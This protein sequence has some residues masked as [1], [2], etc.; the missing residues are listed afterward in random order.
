MYGFDLRADP[1]CIQGQWFERRPPTTLVINGHRHLGTNLDDRTC[2]AAAGLAHPT[3]LGTVPL[4]YLM[5]KA[6]ARLACTHFYDIKTS[7]ILSRGIHNAIAI[8]V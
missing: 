8:A 4:A 2:F 7:Q 5:V 3:R 6:E 1:Q